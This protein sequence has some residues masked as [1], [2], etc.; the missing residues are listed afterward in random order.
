MRECL[1]VSLAPGASH[2]DNERV[3]ANQRTG[4][5]LGLRVCANEGIGL[6]LELGL[7]VCANQGTGCGCG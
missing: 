4:L 1:V 3:C 2:A 6:G 5:G 7:G